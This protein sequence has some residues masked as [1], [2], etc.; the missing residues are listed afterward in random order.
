MEQLISQYKSQ[1]T[2]ERDAL[3]I[4]LS[5]IAI[6]NKETG[7][8]EVKLDDI[9]H[10]TTEVNSEADGEEDAMER[11]ATMAALETRYR[12]IL[13]ALEKIENGTYGICEISGEAIEPDR[14]R[15]NPSARTCQSH[16]N[17]E[18]TLSIV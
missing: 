16:M 6:Q 8:W 15:V 12:T 11:A 18:A 7:D 9:E 14:L 2:A 13:H 10:D 4:E 5:S 17:E 3:I 1:L